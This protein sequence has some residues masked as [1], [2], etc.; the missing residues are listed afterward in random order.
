[1]ASPTLASAPGDCCFTGFKHEGTAKGSTVELAGLKTYVSEPKTKSNKIV[2]YYA[3]VY[4][5]M[6]INAQLIQDYFASHGQLSLLS[7]DRV[8]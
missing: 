2:F 1:M 3:D 5:P 7:F 8:I 6:Y 4:S